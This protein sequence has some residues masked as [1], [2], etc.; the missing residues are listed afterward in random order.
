VLFLGDIFIDL[1]ATSKMQIKKQFG[2][3]ILVSGHK[4][5]NVFIDISY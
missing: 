5:H 1:S 2:Y 3:I 4:I